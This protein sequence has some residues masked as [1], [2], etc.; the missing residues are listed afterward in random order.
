MEDVLAVYRRP[1]DPQ[2]PVICLDEPPPLIGETRT[3]LPVPPGHAQRDDYEDERRGTANHCMSVAPLAGWRQVSV[4]ATQTARELAHEIQQ[5]RDVDYPK[6]EKVVRVWDNLNTPAPAS[7][8]KAF[9]PQEARRLLKHL[10]IH[11]TP[12]PASWLDIAEI[13]LSVFTKQCLER[14][15]DDIDTLR[16]EAMAWAERR[17]ASRA[18]VDWQFTTD[19]A[20]IKRK[21]L[22]PQ[23]KEEEGTRAYPAPPYVTSTPCWQSVVRIRASQRMALAYRRRKI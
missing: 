1:Y 8:Y 21:R 19:N 5:W 10:E 7:L 16:S 12:K 6:A 9:A 13:E 17:K 18:G 22:N 23:V 2:R 3:P 20:R 11:D 14:R 15:L 4:R